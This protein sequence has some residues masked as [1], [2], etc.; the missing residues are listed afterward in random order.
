MILAGTCDEELIHRLPLPLAQLYRKTHTVESPAEQH[1]TALELWAA[2]LKLLG[3]VALVTYADGGDPAFAPR[4]G[5]FARPQ[6]ADWWRA[7]RVLL[8]PLAAR[9]DDGLRRWQQLLSS[10]RTDLPAAARLS[11]VLRNEPSTGQGEVH[12]PD[13]FDLLCDYH[14]RKGPPS[15]GAD[16][17]ERTAAVLLAAA[18]DTF[19]ILDPLA[20]R[21]LVYVGAVRRLATRGWEAERFDLTGEAG[22][23]LSSLS[24]AEADTARLPQPECVYLTA[25][26]GATSGMCC[27]HPLIVHDPAAGEILFLTERRG[28]SRTEYL[29]YTSGRL[30][31]RQDLAAEPRPFLARLL[32]P[33]EVAPKAGAV[34]GLFRLFRRLTG[35]AEAAVEEQPKP[36]GAAPSLPTLGNYELLAKLAE[37]GMGWVYKGRHRETG[38]LVAIKVVPGHVARNETLLRRFE[39]EWRAASK[40]DHP[41]IVRALDYCGTGVTPFL[42]MEFVAGESLGQRVER[43]GKLPE[44]EAVRLIVQVCHGLD[45]A[46]KQ[47]IIHRDVKPDNILVTPD[48]TAKVTDLG[49]VKDLE[50]ELQLTKT[51]YGLG[52]Q[53]FMAPEQFQDAKHADARC[54]VYSVAATLYVLVTGELP[55]GKSPNPWESWTKKTNNE[56]TPPRQLV[57]GLSE[58]T[59]RAICRAMSADPELRPVSCGAF[60][61]ELI[62]E[63]TAD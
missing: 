51:G 14:D 42:V 24:F 43:D 16:F 5:S 20:G 58:R 49:L 37:G 19:R 4:V 10:P 62:G 26:A 11:A 48:G 52:T 13:L 35:G 60:A 8:P 9:R 39:R 17:Q 25:A 56:L 27:L 55:F 54:D 29:S 45:R 31:A 32:A 36:E 53:D 12:L 21:R 46:H 33:A 59:D 1:Q 7:L 15:R 57:P 50:T 3:S 18:V 44:A 40:L 38:Q 22:R 63:S 34:G 2:A 47:G 61:A 6:L 41:H 30:L 23:R 28:P